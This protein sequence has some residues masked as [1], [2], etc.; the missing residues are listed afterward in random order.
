[1][2]AKEVRQLTKLLAGKQINVITKGMSVA[3]GIKRIIALVTTPGLI[4]LDS[5][6]IFKLFKRSKVLSLLSAAAKGKYAASL[7]AKKISA[8]IKKGQ[9]AHCRKLIFNV[10]GNEGMTLYDVNEI[11]TPIYNLCHPKADIV[12]GAMVEKRMR[13]IEVVVAAGQ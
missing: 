13:G 1:M 10:T 7:L 2:S 12:F 5:S 4:N 8:K 9:I 3:E 6:D 11:A